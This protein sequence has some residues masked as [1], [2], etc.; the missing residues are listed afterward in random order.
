[1]NVQRVFVQ[2]VNWNFISWS[3]QT[4]NSFAVVH[5]VNILNIKQLLSDTST[6]VLLNWDTWMSSRG[7][8]ETENN[9]WTIACWTELL[10]L[11][12]DLSVRFTPRFRQLLLV[13][14]LTIRRSSSSELLATD[15][16]LMLFDWCVCMFFLFQGSYRSGK[17]GKSRNLSGQGKSGKGRGKTLFYWKSQGKWKIGATRCQSFGAKMHQIWFPLGLRPEPC[18]GSLQHSPDL[19]AGILVGLFAVSYTHLTLPTI[20]RV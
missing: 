13:V 6:D 11:T 10:L 18:W 3:T 8:I 1:M 9:L 14:F 4:I 7:E 20:L 2:Q 12:Q 15:S 17:T 16:A 5:V 19:L